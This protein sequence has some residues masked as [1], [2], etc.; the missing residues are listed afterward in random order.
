MH[1]HGALRSGPHRLC[2]RVAP[3][4]PAGKGPARGTP[5]ARSASPGSS[6]PA[7]NRASLVTLQFWHPMDLCA[8]DVMRW[9][10]FLFSGTSGWAHFSDGAAHGVRPKNSQKENSWLP[11]P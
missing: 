11:V 8:P 9:A 3:G 10:H 4:G 5:T 1:R 6:A 7:T 2:T